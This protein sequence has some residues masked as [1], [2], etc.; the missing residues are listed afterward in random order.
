M[1]RRMKRRAAARP[2]QQVQD[3]FQNLQARLGQG[4][5]SLADASTY[6]QTNLLTRQPRQLEF[7]YRGSW[8]VGVAVDA[9]ADDMTRA[10]VDLGS[11]IAP[12]DIEAITGAVH[13]LQVWQSVGDVIRWARLYGGAIG[14]LLIDGQDLASPLRPETIKEGAFRGIVPISRWEL[15]PTFGRLIT[16]YGPDMGKP[17]FYE[18]GAN[19]AA[20][21]GEKVHHTRVIRMEGV[22][23]PYFQR[24]AEQGWGLSIIE[25]MYD[26]LT[27]F[28]SS[29][30]GAAQLVFKAYLRTLKV[31]G[32]TKILAAGGAAEAALAKQVES[33]RRFQQ[34]EGLTVIDAEDEFDTHAYTFAGLDDLLLQFGQQLAGATEIPLVRL[35]GQSPAGLNATGEGDIRNYYD[36]INAKQERTLRSPMTRTF[37]VLHRSATGKEP[38]AGFNYT[39]NPLWQLGEV[40]KAGIAKSTS[41]AVG[42]AYDDGIITKGTALREL[43]QSA[44]VTGVFSNISDAEIKDAEAE[45]PVPGEGEE[46]ALEADA[47]ITLEPGEVHPQG[48]TLQ[49]VSLNGAQVASM[50]DIVTQVATGAIPRESGIAMLL[51]AFPID[52]DAAERIMGTVGK[53]FVPAEPVKAEAPDLDDDKVTPFPKAK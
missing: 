44:D 47:D 52:A 21:M 23:L 49:E 31:K 39:F 41:D 35:F 46:P 12:K 13:D 28:D 40:E 34:T 27:A 20:L 10:G 29:T 30:T 24:V 33:I 48:H 18:V 43:R 36:G 14:V 37:D 51:A 1:T 22:R 2:T 4:A 15:N 6:V 7:M 50:V 42:Q 25:R 38:P 32:L 5:G 3:S 9:V 45:P 53:G 8:I 19:A 26:R 17:E 16:E 11:G